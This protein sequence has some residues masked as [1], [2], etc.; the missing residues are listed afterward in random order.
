MEREEAVS[1]VFCEAQPRMEFMVSPSAEGLLEVVLLLFCACRRSLISEGRLLSG[2]G[3][4]V[5]GKVEAG[6]TVV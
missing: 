4:G 1:G 6:G 3:S 2:F 5:F